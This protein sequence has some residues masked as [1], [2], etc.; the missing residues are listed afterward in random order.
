MAKSVLIAYEQL[1]RFLEKRYYWN[2]YITFYER[3]WGGPASPYGVWFGKEYET[4]RE[5]LSNYIGID[6]EEIDDCFF[7]K[8]KQGRYYISPIGSKINAYLLHSENYIPL[9]W[10]LLFKDEERK[11]SYT[12]SGFGAL[13]YDGIYYD[14]TINLA[15]ERLKGASAIIR[16]TFEKYGK[17]YLKLPISDRLSQIQSGVLELETWL[18]R[19]DPSGCMLLNYG[20]ICSLIHPYTMTNELSVKEMWH[21][22]SLISEDR[23]DEAQSVLNVVI[24]KWEDIRRKAAGEIS[25][26]SIQ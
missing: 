14:T 23:M 13:D 4:F 16:N 19:F 7:I 12:H 15:V 8:D 5:A 10:F 17:T 9:H 2:N 1:D 20:E 18:S 26:F 11:F 24:Q 6:K 25:K 3:Y 22:L 21:I